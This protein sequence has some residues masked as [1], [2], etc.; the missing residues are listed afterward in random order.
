LLRRHGSEER[1]KV[2]SKAMIFL[3]HLRNVIKTERGRKGKKLVTSG[4]RNLLKKEGIRQFDLS[5]EK[6]RRESHH[7]A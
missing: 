5:T 6:S 3:S 2:I 4:A 7:F 1:K